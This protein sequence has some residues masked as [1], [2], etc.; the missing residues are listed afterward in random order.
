MFEA[1][2]KKA[3]AFG[4]SV[5]RNAPWRL[6]ARL[7]SP[8]MHY[9]MSLYNSSWNRF[10][11]DYYD[12]VIDLDFHQFKSFSVVFYNTFASDFPTETYPKLAHNQK[13]YK[14][15][16]ILQ[17]QEREQAALDACDDLIP[18]YWFEKY[19][20]YRMLENGIK[21]DSKELKRQM[22]KINKSV[23]KGGLDQ[24][25]YTMQ[26]SAGVC[27]LDPESLPDI[28]P[29][30][31]YNGLL[32][33]E[34]LIYYVTHPHSYDKFRKQ[35]SKGK[36]KRMI[37]KENKQEISVSLSEAKPTLVNIPVMPV[38]SDK[39]TPKDEP[40]GVPFVPYTD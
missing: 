21:L 27:M 10:F 3:A 36:D 33:K 5:D 31:F 4:F 23:F 38:T 25:F 2:V 26:F 35:L 13:I 32:D 17:V 24:V 22:K 8:Q 9:Y 7:D 12:K 6:I 18:F 16:V 30:F 14:N 34:T 19:Y 39:G 11:G 40:I 15:S 1:Y 20:N 29:A 37:V 28:R